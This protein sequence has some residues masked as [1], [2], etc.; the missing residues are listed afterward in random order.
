MVVD[1]RRER[2]TLNLFNLASGLRSRT[3]DRRRD[4]PPSPRW[5]GSLFMSARRPGWRPPPEPLSARSVGLFRFGGQGGLGESPSI[6]VP[7]RAWPP[8]IRPSAGV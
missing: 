2:I 6:V 7:C 8:A 1:R 3:V 5:K 4:L